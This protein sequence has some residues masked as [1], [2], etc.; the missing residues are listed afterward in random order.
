MN[1]DK[2]WIVEVLSEIREYALENDLHNL[3][4]QLDDVANVALA[5]ISSHIEK[6]ELAGSRH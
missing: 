2:S 1:P 3:A 4:E 5:E 6:P